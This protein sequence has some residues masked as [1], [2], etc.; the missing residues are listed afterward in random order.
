MLQ[1]EPTYTVACIV[2]RATEQLVQKV[3]T[4]AY[5]A[6]RR[7]GQPVPVTLAGF[8]NQRRGYRLNPG[9]LG[10][11]PQAQ[12]APYDPPSS[13]PQTLTSNLCSSCM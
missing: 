9:M 11:L 3:G 7:K 12:A 6:R 8:V 1:A 5:P 10:L 2:P 13:K 4:A